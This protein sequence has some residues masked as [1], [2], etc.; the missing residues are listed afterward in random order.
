MNFV[1]AIPWSAHAFGF[2]ADLAAK[3]TVLL[4]VGLLVQQLVARWRASLGSA[5]ANACLLGLL[6]VPCS[7]LLLP[8]IELK[9][10]PATSSNMRSPVRALAAADRGAVDGDGD[11]SFERLVSIGA[12][13]RR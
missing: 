10:L 3:V 11:A 5:V 4:G 6:L 2:G 8:A 1:T 12:R 7:A 13:S 9:W